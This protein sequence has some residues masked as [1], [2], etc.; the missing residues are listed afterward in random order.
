MKVLY[1]CD[2]YQIYVSSYFP[3]SF[4]LTPMALVALFLFRF[5]NMPAHSSCS[6]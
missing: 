5:L 6:F 3:S 1:D 2:I 4:V